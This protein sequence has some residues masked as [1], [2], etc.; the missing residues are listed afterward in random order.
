MAKSVLT[1]PYQYKQIDYGK[2]INPLTYIPIKASWGWQPLWFLLDSGADTTLLTVSLG[3]SLGLDFDITKKTQLFG[4]GEK[5]VSA[6]QGKV[7]LRLGREV[8]DVRCYF[9]DAKE[10]TLLLGRLDVFDRFN[11]LFNTEKRKIILFPPQPVP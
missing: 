7:T 8:L 5:S 9:I 3:R 4:I 6:Y 10:S 2:I 11:I 1:F